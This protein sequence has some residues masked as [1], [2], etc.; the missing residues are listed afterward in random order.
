[1]TKISTKISVDKRDIILLARAYREKD[2][3]M[4]TEAILNMVKTF[5]DDGHDEFADFLYMTMIDN[6]GCCVPMEGKYD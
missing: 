6:S 5:R 1:M 4:F 2:E 3:S